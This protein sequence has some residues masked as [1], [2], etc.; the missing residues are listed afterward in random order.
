MPPQKRASTMQAEEALALRIAFERERRGWS[1]AGLASRLSKIGCPMTQ[2]GI[3]KIENGEPRRRITFDEAVAFAKV[4]EVPLDELATSP[5]HVAAEEAAS[6][7]RG[8]TWTLESIEEMAER[9][10]EQKARLSELLRDGDADD[11][12]TKALWRAGFSPPM[13]WDEGGADIDWRAQMAKWV[14]WRFLR[15]DAL[16]KWRTSHAPALADWSSGAH[17]FKPGGAAPASEDSEADR[18]RDGAQKAAD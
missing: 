15:V 16:W 3:W 6:I 17:E 10:H 1:P 11:L 12:I 13:P 18:P 5:E 2:S 14:D 9:L 7:W 4:F 8:I